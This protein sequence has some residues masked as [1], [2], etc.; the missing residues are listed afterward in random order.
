V[1]RQGVY[2]RGVE[3]LLELPDLPQ[4]AALLEFLREQASPPSGPGDYTLGSWQLH[5]HPDLIG[6]LCGLA[7]GWPIT[8]AYGVAILACEGIAAVVA[9]GTDYLVVRVDRLPAGVDTENP[10]PQWSFA[11]GSWHVISPLQSQLTG[12]EAERILSEMVSA[13]I[14]HAASLS[15]FNPVGSS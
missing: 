1:V 15:G 6:R 2:A 11:R 13:A 3:P 4:N 9:L 5:T 8:A 10:A 12:A 14:A 7:P